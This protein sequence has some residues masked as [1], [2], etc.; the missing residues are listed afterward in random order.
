M[1]VAAGEARA[2][3][4]FTIDELDHISEWRRIPPVITD[5]A[6]KTRWLAIDSYDRMML[7]VDLKLPIE[8]R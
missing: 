4:A 8:L 7:L 6:A 3:D 1:D 2:L 5:A